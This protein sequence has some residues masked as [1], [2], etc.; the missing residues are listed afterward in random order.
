VTPSSDAG[1]PPVEYYF[2]FVDVQV[3]GGHD[4]GWQTSNFYADGGLLTNYLYGYT[5]WARDGQ[6]NETDPAPLGTAATFIET[7]QSAPSVV[8]T[9]TSA[10][11]ATSE[12]FTNLTV[13]QSGL[14]F[15]STTAGGDGGINQWVQ[16]T[17]DQATGLTPDTLYTFRFKAR[18]QDAVE[19]DWSPERT[20]RTR[21][22]VPSAP[23]LSNATCA[24][25]DVAIGDDINPSYTTYA[26]HCASTSPTDANWEGLYA[27]AS[28]NP[29]GSAIYRTQAEWGTTTLLT[30]A[31]L[32]TYGFEVIAQNG[33][34]VTTDP[35]PEASLTTE[36]CGSG[37]TCDDGILNQGEDRIDCG[38]P[39]PPCACLSDG[40]CDNGQYCDGVE[41]CDA[42]G[43]CQPGTSVDCDDGIACT[44]DS[45]NETTDQCDNVPND[46]LCDNGLFCDGAEW[47]DPAVGCQDGTDPCG[48]DETCDEEQDVCESLPF[49][50]TLP[51]PAVCKGDANGDGVVDPSDAGL[52]KFWYG[53][54]DPIS[55]CSYD[56]NC[57]GQ[58]NPADVGLVKF[59]YGACD[60]SS[61]LPCWAE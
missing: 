36:S 30:M 51:D 13:S 1:S 4:S 6:G 33:S 35:G 7:P 12:T 61:E 27:D 47:C 52:V 39:C 21:A 17:G 50:A 40:E 28:G 56:V 53:D 29:T 31:E 18:N 14:Y 24:S 5:V 20:R 42:W 2:E 58:I 59:Y 15:D 44:V 25:M 46:A 45:C 60:I 49:C 11:L 54:T 43:E 23:V 57:D 8:T 32:T 19:T 10:T 3:P 48:P 9:D 26:I 16:S 34:G 37:E 38:G 55:L 22:A 41:T